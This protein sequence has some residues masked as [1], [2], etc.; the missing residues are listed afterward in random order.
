MMRRGRHVSPWLKGRRTRRVGRALPL[1]LAFAMVWGAIALAS[2]VDVSVVDVTAP[3]GSVTLAPGGSAPIVI[4]MSVSGNQ[5]GD[6]TF[7]VYRDWTLQGGT[8]TGSNP[9]TFTVPPQS[10]GDTTTFTASGTVTVAA[11]QADGTFTLAVGAF[12]IT[13]SNATGAKLEARQSSN[14]EV[15][16]EALQGDVTPPVITINEPGDGDHFILGEIVNAD[17][18]CVDNESSVTQCE[19]TVAHGHPIDTSTP[20]SHTFRVD[21]ASAGGTSYLEHT[22]YVDYAACAGATSLSILQP[23]N[24]DGS[25]VFKQKSTVPAKFQVCDVDGNPIGTAG[26]VD[27]FNLVRTTNGTDSGEITEVVDSTVKATSDFRYDP[28]AG[29]WIFNMNTK[30]L[31]AGKTY[32]YKITLDSGQTIEFS[33]GLK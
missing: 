22:Y 15:T 5:A 2:D 14:Y 23:I 7:K 26:V 20:G 9:E 28:T 30:N 18:S 11:G 17:F 3:T 19:G 29:Q 31:S 27:S 32:W 25:S 33:F 12:D 24:A 21:A 6:A 10:G 13:N 4:N 1:A 8:F 16:V